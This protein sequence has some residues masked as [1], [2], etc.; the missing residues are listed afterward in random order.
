MCPQTQ[1]Y[2]VTTASTSKSPHLISAIKHIFPIPQTPKTKIIMLCDVCFRMLRGQEGRIWKGTYDLHYAHHYD[3][4]TFLRSAMMNC[5]ICRVLFEE[6]E[7][8]LQCDNGT[9]LEERDLN[10]TAS[11]SVLHHPRVSHLYRLDFKMRCD[12]I[13]SQRTFLLKKT[14]SGDPPFRTPISHNTSSDEVYQLARNWMDKCKCADSHRLPTWYPARLISLEELKTQDFLD[15]RRLVST[16]QRDHHTIDQTVVKLVETEDWAH[17]PGHGDARYVTLSHCWGTDAQKQMKLDSKNIE[18]FKRGIRLSDL[19]KTFRHA[20]EF[21]ARL[22]RVGY[23]WID[24]LCIKQGFEEREDWLKQSAVMDRVYSETFLNISATAST[25]S[26]GGLFYPR[27][28]ELLLEDEVIVNIEGIPGVVSRRWTAEVH[29]SETPVP[30]IASAIQWLE[31]YW[32]ASYLLLLLR[33]LHIMLGRYIGVEP[34]DKTD[35]RLSLRSRSNTVTS[36]ETASSRD[37]SPSRHSDEGFSTDGDLKFLRRC[38]ILDVSS[39]TNHIDRAPV[40][41]RGWVLQE[42]LMAPRVLHFCHDQIAWECAEFDAAEGQPQGMPN[43][44]LTSD[45]IIEE[46]RLKGLDP[47]ADGRRLRRIRLQG[48]DDPDTHLQPVIYALEL[49][50]RIV[51][52]YS[53]TAITNPEDKL[54]AL[55]GMARWMARKIGKPDKPAEYVAG[56]WRVHLASQLLWRTDTV[57]RQFDSTFE[58]LTTATEEYRAPSFSWAS[59]DAEKGHGITYADIT[60]RDLFISVEEVS[61]KPKSDDNEYGMI[62]SAHIILQGKLRKATLFRRPKGRFGWRLVDR[63][64]LDGEEHTNVYLDCPARDGDSILGPDAD[65]YVVPAAKGERTASEESKYLTCLI[66]QLVKGHPMGNVFRRI[67]LTRLSPW[68]DHVAVH[69][70]SLL[71]VYGSDVDMPHQGY[72]PQTGMHRILLI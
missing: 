26:D 58:C 54:I 70:D 32:L 17:G 39:W 72:D 48:F 4:K 10:I 42:R 51:E 2:F 45:G 62:S 38:T 66:L 43:F 19:P 31:T 6:L 52:V 36:Q 53:R 23:I 34:K 27:R 21:A 5:G 61:I 64:A 67:G 29:V 30:L 55:S 22:P 3:G 59:I 44:Q 41:R 47:E 63:E 8:K 12:R 25:N 49:W 57:F 56:L 18:D 40:N 37:S 71:E 65:V 1:P 11:L 33:R 13:R 24:S 69:N 20:I 9:P 68:A 35:T 28:P 14:D 60:D 16:S 50:R 7:L 15:T 46:S